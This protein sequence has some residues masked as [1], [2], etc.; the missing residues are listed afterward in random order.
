[1]ANIKKDCFEA[2]IRGLAQIAFSDKIPSGF[3]IFFSILVISPMSAIGAIIGALL[4]SLISYKYY[5]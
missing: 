2:T 5:K 1:M 4:S 3:I